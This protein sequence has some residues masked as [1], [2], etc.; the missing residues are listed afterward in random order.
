M[1]IN[2]MFGFCSLWKANTRSR[3][4]DG[5]FIDRGNEKEVGIELEE[6][7]EATHTHTQVKVYSVNMYMGVFV[8]YVNIQ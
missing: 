2:T 7:I 3:N 8:L 1:I 6:E 4:E 5:I